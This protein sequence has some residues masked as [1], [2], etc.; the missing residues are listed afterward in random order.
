MR[1]FRKTPL[2]QVFPTKTQGITL[3]HGLLTCTYYFRVY[4]RTSMHAGIKKAQDQYRYL[5]KP[6]F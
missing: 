1:V 2:V 4:R 3:V 6:I 5:E